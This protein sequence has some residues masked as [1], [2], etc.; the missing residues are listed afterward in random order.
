[1]KKITLCKKHLFS[2]IIICAGILVDQISKIIVA[3]NM[4]YGKV[5]SII[6]YIF[7]FRY[8]TNDGVAFGWLSGQRWLFMTVSA[9]AI[10]AMIVYA[11]YSFSELNMLYVWGLS[12]VISGGIGNMIDRTFLGYVVDFIEFAFVDFATF[13]IADSC[14]CVGAFILGLAIVIDIYREGKKIKESK[15]DEDNGRAEK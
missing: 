12:L 1:M 3:G 15:A 4:T 6:P 5:V 13:N 10:I 14:V 7:D 11:L 9:V 8:V 2:L